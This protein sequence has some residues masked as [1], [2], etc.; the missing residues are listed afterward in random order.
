M[1]NTRSFCTLL[2][3]FFAG[4][5]NGNTLI[6]PQSRPRHT[7]DELWQKN[8]ARNN[9]ILASARGGGIKN[10]ETGPHQIRSAQLWHKAQVLPAIF[11]KWYMN[12]M[13]SHELRTKC[14]SAGFLALAGDICAQELGHYLTSKNNQQL[15][16]INPHHSTSEGG[17]FDKRR[18]FA[19]YCDGFLCT[20]P[21]LH[22]VYEFYEK[23]LPIEGESN[24][25]DTDTMT[26]QQKSTA[27][28]KRFQAA[29]IHVL[30]D[31]IFM[32]VFYVFAMM[33]VTS[34]LEGRYHL[35]F[36]E[37]RNDFVPAVKASWVASLMGLAPMQLISFHFLPMELRVL[38]VN[39]QDVIWVMVMS[40]VTHRNRH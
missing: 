10:P 6:H 35:L 18:M 21:I 16:K 25:D 2:F 5:S 29:L 3:S 22:Y 32:A 20:G 19:M 4:T 30:F 38:A 8:V 27:A 14:I 24:L 15:N 23:I 40:W 31:N 34:I 7:V 36:H 33:V 13:E 1:V 9:Q 26:P 28:R 12:Q 17:K 39:F 11:G 37:I